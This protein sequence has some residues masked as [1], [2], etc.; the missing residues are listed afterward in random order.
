MLRKVVVDSLGKGQRL[1]K[2]LSTVVENLSRS[3]IK[4]IIDSGEVKAN[5]K[6]VKPKFILSEGDIITYEEKEPV[7][8][9]IKP[10]DID[11]NIVYEDEDI[12]IVDKEA[13]M[14]VHPAP[15]HYDDTLVNAIMYHCGDSL[16]GINGEIRPGIVHRIDKDTSGILVICKN[17]ISHRHL[18]K[19]FKDHSIN[20]IYTGICYNHFK[21]GSGTIDEPI[22]RNPYNRLKMAINR[23]SGRRAV[24][25][26]SL[27]ENLAMNF[28]LLDFKLE[29]GRTHQIRVHMSS[30]SHPLLGDEVYGPKKGRLSV[31]GQLLHARKLG[32]IHPSTGEYIEFESP[33][34]DRFE[35]I[36]L[37]LRK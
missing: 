24:T 35:K 9:D 20:R 5:D 15:G 1:D 22:G 19:Q 34:P 13:G 32:F 8:V 31:K 2:Y 4:K 29:T 33:L 21:E 6:R 30:I 25:H 37:K 14:V 18:A 23:K 3:Q 16:S 17:D 11:I 36:L 28:S 26:Y 12:L 7:E 10:V 27:I